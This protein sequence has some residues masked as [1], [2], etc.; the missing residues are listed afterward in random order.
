MLDFDSF[1][2][3][4]TSPFELLSRIA[5]PPPFDTFSMDY[6][7]GFDSN[8]TDLEIPDTLFSA[9]PS[10]FTLPFVGVSETEGEK[11][12]DPVLWETLS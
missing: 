10:T 7:G 1:C 9:V 11:G 5:T 6:S 4:F 8:F 12:K 3:T 2:S